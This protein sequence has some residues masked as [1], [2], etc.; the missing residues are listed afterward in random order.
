VAKGV[1]HPREVGQ[2]PMKYEESK[3]A[4]PEDSFESQM[5]LYPDGDV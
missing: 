5:R 1:N 4:T 2:N 3:L